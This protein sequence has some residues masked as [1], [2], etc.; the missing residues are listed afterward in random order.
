MRERQAKVEKH[1]EQFAEKFSGPPGP[2]PRPGLLW[3]PESHRWHRPE[4]EGGGEEPSSV[5]PP[6]EPGPPSQVQQSYIDDA[7]KTASLDHVKR[8]VEDSPHDALVDDFDDEA[9]AF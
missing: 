1:A 5:P 7:A 9:D 3:N 8:R 2:P 4:A 6:P